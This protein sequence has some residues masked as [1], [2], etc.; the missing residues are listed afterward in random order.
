LNRDITDIDDISGH[1]I[2]YWNLKFDKLIQLII[3]SSM[4]G[5]LCFICLLY[6]LCPCSNSRNRYN[7]NDCGGNG[8][9]WVWRF[10]I[11]AGY[12]QTRVFEQC[13]WCRGTGY[14]R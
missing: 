14:K 7:C 4:C 5:L 6:L 13:V 10:S 8:G 2:E 11:E 3:A 9:H 12:I 1:K